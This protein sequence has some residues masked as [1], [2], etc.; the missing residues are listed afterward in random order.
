MSSQQNLVALRNTYQVLLE[1]VN[2]LTLIYTDLNRSIETLETFKKLKEREGTTPIMVPVGSFLSMI[3][4][5]IRMDKVAV[6]VGAGI[7]VEMSPEEALEELKK[8]L[9]EVKDNI[10]KMQVELRQIE[11]Q[12]ISAERVGGAKKGSS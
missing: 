2:R 8:R 10:L 6:Q 1:E 3:M 9:E 12:L 5:G 4:S 7:Y 11:A